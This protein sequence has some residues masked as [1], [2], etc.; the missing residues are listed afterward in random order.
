MCDTVTLEVYDKNMMEMVYFLTKKQE[1]MDSIDVAKSYRKNGRKVSDRT[2]RR[3]FTK[4]EKECFDYYPYARH[5]SMGLQPIFVMV[6]NPVDE[7]FMQLIPYMDYITCCFDKDLKKS[8]LL[9]YQIPRDYTKKF[10]EFWAKAKKEELIE[11]YTI[12]Y[13]NSPSY[14]C[15]PFHKILKSDGEL[16][17]SNYSSFDNS[18]FREL[19]ENNYKNMLKPA[20]S[21]HILKNPLI[22]PAL[23]EF[24]REHYTNRKAWASLKKRLGKNV[25]KYLKNRRKETDG[26]GY[27]MTQRTIRN[28]NTVYYKDFFN[29][30]IVFY[31]PWIRKSISYFLIYKTKSVDKAPEIFEEMSKR[32][33][34]QWVYP[35]SN[36]GGFVIYQI[37]NGQMMHEVLRVLRKMDPEAETQLVLRDPT[38]SAKYFTPAY[39]KMDYTLFDPETMTWQY[40]HEKYMKTLD[41]LITSRDV[42]RAKTKA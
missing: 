9:R 37:T 12:Y 11:D 1:F 20:M 34:V 10:D 36:H 14:F 22:V 40:D 27:Y 33:L 5:E 41:S 25:W 28:L 30:T 2:L 24:Y 23:L 16:D 29:Q 6:V 17:F 42:I 4:L 21:A 38:E 19:F 15:S 7:G 39:L 26:V 8:F 35:M 32:A 3:W 31:D 13:V 18:Y